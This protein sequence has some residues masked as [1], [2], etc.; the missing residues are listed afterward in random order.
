MKGTFDEEWETILF[1]QTTNKTVEVRDTA[2]RGEFRD[3]SMARADSEDECLGRC[4]NDTFCSAFS[5]C[6]RPDKRRNCELFASNRI[7]HFFQ[8]TDTK[9][10]ILLER[11]KR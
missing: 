1:R 11:L 2:I 9:S 4:K 7:S 5:Y 10:Y 8:E 3:G 6:T